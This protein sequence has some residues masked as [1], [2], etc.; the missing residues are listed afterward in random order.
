M[1]HGTRVRIGDVGLIYK[2]EFHLLFHAGSQP[3]GQQ[4]GADIPST[5]EPLSIGEIL[6]RESRPPGCLHSETVRKIGVDTVVPT[7]A[8]VLPISPSSACL[9]MHR[10]DPRCSHPWSSPGIV[11]QHW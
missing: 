7:P 10:L 8:Y 11:V 5:F 6:V 2:G 4:L 9:K 3:V 1:P